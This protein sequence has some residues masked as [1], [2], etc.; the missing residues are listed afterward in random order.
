[1]ADRDLLASLVRTLYD[2]RLALIAL[3]TV[4]EAVAQNSAVAVLALLLALPLSYVPLRHWRAMVDRRQLIALDALLGAMLT[5]LVTDPEVMLLY[6]LATVV[7][8]GLIGGRLGAALATG[9]LGG[10]LAAA[11]AYTALT[12]SVA[13]GTVATITGFIALYVLCAFGSLRLTRLLHDYN[14]A[15]ESARAASRQAAQAEERTRLAREMHDSLSK[16]VQG[17]HLLALAVAKRLTEQ[18]VE[19]RLRADADRLV[20]ACDIAT[21]DA[22]RLLHDLRSPLDSETAQVWT[23]VEQVVLAWQTRTAGAAEVV[24]HT[25]PT[26]SELPAVVLYEIGC[27]VGEAL[28][29]ASRHGGADR[30]QVELEPV[31]G[32]LHVRVRDNGGGFSAPS[33]LRALHRT[34]HY[35]VIGMG[36][37]AQR[38]GGSLS[39]ERAAGG[40]TLVTLSVPAP[41]LATA[42]RVS[43]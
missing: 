11:T 24:D 26:G 6:S 32:W 2:L 15:N 30:V 33:D 17:T 19:P 36:E 37:R 21:R 10:F 14:R 12:H 38:L 8:S 39:V 29:N 23:H 7:L 43:S 40:G 22:R 18:E 42:E 4:V 5:V 41:A 31:D 34:G 16:T 25:N 20:T 1:V 28:D 27:V 13:P 9:I 35:G 3:A